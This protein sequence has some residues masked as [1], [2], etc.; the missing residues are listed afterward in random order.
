MAD[1]AARYLSAHVAQNCNA[2]TAGIYRGS[3][4]NHILPALGMMP[5]AAVETAHV[6][7]LHYRLR[8]RPRAANRALSVLSKMFSLAAAWGLVADG[9]NPCKGVRKYREKKRERFLTREEY[10]RLGQALAE[11]EAEA[12]V[13]GAVSPY[14]IAA[15]R[16]L[17]LTGCRLNEILT[18]RWDDIDRTAGEFRLRDGKTGARMVPLT[19]TAE[20]VLAGI[21]RVPRNPWVIAGKQPGTHLST[22]TQ[23]WYRLRARA[24][25]D[26]VRIHDLRHS[27]ASRALAAGESLSMIGKLLG[28][29]DIQSTARYAHLARETERL[30]AARVGGSIGAS[31]T[32]VQPPEQARTA[33]DMNMTND[34]AT[35]DPALGSITERTVAALSAASDTVVWDRALTGFGVR[36]YPSGAKVYVVQTR[37]PAGT[38]RISVGR[39]GVIGASEARRRAA[40]I[41]ARIRAGEE[42]VPEAQKAES[43]TVAALAARYLREHVAVRCKPTTATQ[44]RLAIERY[45]VPAL[46]TSAVSSLGRAQVADLQ[47]ALRDRPAMA[48]LAIA[49]LSRMIDQ[50][51]AWGVAGET[52]NPCRSVPRYRTRRRERF[53][54]D[55]EFQRLGR[56]LDELEATGRI[57]PHAAAAL[58]LLMLTGCRRNEIL[59]L[60]WE[61][62]RLEAQ[63]LQLADSKTGP[64]TVSLSPEA[65]HGAGVDRAPARQPLGDPR[66]QARRPALQPVRALA[67]GARPRRPG[68]RA[69][70]RPAPLLRHPARW[71][72]A[73]ACR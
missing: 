57:S 45:I 67:Q 60:R 5:L 51:I 23:D 10:R 14:A 41:V 54:T 42:P 66:C 43:I 3:L 39:H 21:E 12:G 15:L 13:D 22:I 73:R 25:L 35:N 24:G 19:P 71:P 70:A 72:W 7:A 1:L 38:R 31:V 32:S 55:A 58:R 29:A 56:T 6:A 65:A 62:V 16:L 50:A 49:T 40:L 52:S 64:R 46:G 20:T 4:E 59:T 18:L 63:E 34:A 33:P 53:L 9:T 47:H 8:A 68:R 44:Y 2:H 11:A 37:G 28:H 30:S 69:P 36:V 17:M 61:D 27:Y 26:D 48:N